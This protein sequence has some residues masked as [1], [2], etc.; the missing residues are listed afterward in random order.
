MT[1]E[2]DDTTTVRELR[3]IVQQF[4]DERDWRHFHNAKNLSMSLA[5]EV[6]ELM[7]HFQWLT[8]EQVVARQGYCKDQVADELAD[9]ACYALGLANAL[10]I[11]LTSAIRTKMVKNRIK[12]PEPPAST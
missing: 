7:E 11:D 1:T 4:V 10:D 5:I 12:H 3:G 2:F 8:T 6:G 9:V